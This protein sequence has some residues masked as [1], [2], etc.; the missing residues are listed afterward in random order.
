MGD[1]ISRDSL[2]KQR[3]M[4]EIREGKVKITSPLVIFIKKLGIR[5]TVLAF[6]VVSGLS[7]SVFFYFLNKTQSLGFLSM[8]LPGLKVFLLAIPYGYIALF[9]LTFIIANYF[10][11]QLN[12]LRRGRFY[13]SYFSL[14]FFLISLILGIF[15]IYWGVTS[16]LNGGSRIPRD[17]SVYGTIKDIQHGEAWVEEEDG[18]VVRVI[19]SKFKLEPTSSLKGKVL[20]AVG[21]REEKNQENPSFYPD[22]VQILPK[23]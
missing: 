23:D 22:K 9:L 11:S 8:G 4:R 19:L 1:Q 12:F 3:V 5:S 16:A 18:K 14:I 6:F 2:V 15:F 17:V 21:I 13:S 20:R 7:L 10:Y